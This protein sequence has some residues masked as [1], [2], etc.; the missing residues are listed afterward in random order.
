MI[1]HSNKVVGQSSS[2]LTL[3]VLTLVTLINKV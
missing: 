1:K 2:R 3:T